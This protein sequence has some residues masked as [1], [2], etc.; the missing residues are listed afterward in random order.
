MD[1]V[2]DEVQGVTLYTDLS[3]LWAKAGMQP[4]NG[5]QTHPVY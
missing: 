1:S 3:E 2:I 4:T 5:S